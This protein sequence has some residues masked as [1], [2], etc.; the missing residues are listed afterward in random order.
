MCRHLA[1]IV[2]ELKAPEIVRGLHGDTKA[3]AMTLP[4][5]DV[6]PDQSIN[7]MIKHLHKP[8]SMNTTAQLDLDVV[9][10]ID[11]YR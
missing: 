11:Y 8:D 3:S 5:D 1:T 9:A 7:L 2:P 6:I 4:I 10:F